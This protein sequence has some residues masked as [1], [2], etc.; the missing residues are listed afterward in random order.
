M[1]RKCQVIDQKVAELL[2]NYRGKN[3]VVFWA[4]PVFSRL[5][6][7]CVTCLKD[8]AACNVMVNFFVENTMTQCT[9][10]TNDNIC[11]I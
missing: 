10:S 8:Y 3:L 1:S 4:I 2:G 7:P 9:G 5:L 6:Q 11:V